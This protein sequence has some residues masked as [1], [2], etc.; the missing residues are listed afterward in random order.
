MQ[1]QNFYHEDG[2]TRHTKGPPAENSRRPARRAR[3]P[4]LYYPEPPCV[5]EHLQLLPPFLS[6]PGGEQ[7][8]PLPTV[9]TCQLIIS[10]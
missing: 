3:G 9:K 7:P 4:T 10:G 2:G 6:S 8:E 1:L 5:G